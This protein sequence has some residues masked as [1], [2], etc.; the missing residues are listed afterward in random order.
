LNPLDEICIIRANG[1]IVGRVENGVF[2]KNIRGSTH[3]LRRP[4]ALCLDV[5]SLIDA[6]SC[7]AVKVEI[8]DKD[9]GNVYRAQISTIRAKGFTIERGGAGRQLALRL[10]DWQ[11]NDVPEQL[12]IDMG[13]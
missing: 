13:L 12:G 11:I 6:Q 10:S 1:K 5:Q 3:H 4:A 7:G 2:K 9:S 8:I